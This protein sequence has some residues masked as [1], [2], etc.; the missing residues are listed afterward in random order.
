MVRFACKYQYRIPSSDRFRI[1]FLLPDTVFGCP[2]SCWFDQGFSLSFCGVCKRL[3]FFLVRSFCCLVLE[4]GFGGF[5]FVFICFSI[6]TGSSRP[7]SDPC[8]CCCWIRLRCCVSC[9]R[10]HYGSE[11]L[12]VDG[13]DVGPEGGL[14][15]QGPL[16]AGTFWVRSDGVSL[17]VCVEGELGVCYRPSRLPRGSI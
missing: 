2:Y 6:G 9:L 8:F 17:Q 7:H 11:W 12:V 4:P 10:T 15:R 5:C 14:G 16:H 13:C 3:L 1:L